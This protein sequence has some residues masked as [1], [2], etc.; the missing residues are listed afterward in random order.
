MQVR[1][2]H[3]A[4]SDR[5]PRPGG[6]PG[7][8]AR[9]PFWRNV[10]TIGILAQVVF[11]VLVVIGVAILWNNVASA[12]SRS[13][14]PADFGFLDS[15]AGIPIAEQPIPYSPADPYWRAILVG[16]LN[17]LKVALVGVALASVLGVAIGVGRL[18]GNWLLRQISTWYVEILRNTPLA[19]QIIFWYTAALATLPPTITAPIR[20]PGG[21]YFSN[22]GLAFPF[23]YPGFGFRL[24]WP[25][26]LG[27]I[28]V[29]VAVFVWRRRRLAR[30]E[31]PGRA[32][33]LALVAAVAVGGGGYLVA[34]QGTTSPA[35][36]AVDLTLNRGRGVVFQDID[37]DGVHDEREDTFGY[38]PLTVTIEEGV[39]EARSQNLLEQRRV[40]PSTLRFPLLERGEYQD[41]ELT[42]VN[43]EDADRFDVHWR[44]EPSIG[45]LYVDRN[46]DGA[47]QE[48][49]ELDE[50]GVGFRNVRT[51]LRVTGFERRTVADRDGVFRIPG[52]E[53][54]GATAATEEADEGGGGAGFGVGG[55]FG[56]PAGGGDA[57]G[58]RLEG[59]VT[60][61][62]SGPLVWSTP[63]VPVSNYEGGFRFTPSYLALLLALVVY[64][65]SFI[66]EI[67][68]GGIQAVVK[69]QT[70]AAKALGLSDGQTFG[71]IVFPQAVRIILPPMIS[72]YLN[73]TKN[74]SLGPLAAYGELFAVSTIVANQTGASVPITLMI[75]GAYL[76]IS[77][78]FAFFLNIVNAR[79]AIVER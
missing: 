9:I 42:F 7:A 29:F 23:L 31:R 22:R 62:E 54:I 11:A 64:T 72:Q 63:A 67:V 27:A 32:W 33:P 28:V 56:A 21:F 19:V 49:E 2:V 3:V 70:E 5:P 34:Q 4:R 46:G 79:L 20:L 39:L 75:I 43:E 69:G 51:E 25:W 10:K 59:D 73:L 68:R 35:D 36:L 44:T 45:I 74:S 14:L 57:D 53:P 37:G 55:L 78:V 50:N 40:K 38:V 61:H 48:G 47:W 1:R 52:F 41:V 6:G 76:I 24:W 12:L 60:V 26:L 16:I 18:S 17:T 58:P 8:P 30:S 13:N 65:S 15:R 71:L 66:A 77:F